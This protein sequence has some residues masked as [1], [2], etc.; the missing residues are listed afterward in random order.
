MAPARSRWPIAVLIPS[1]EICHN[2]PQLAPR[3]IISSLCRYSQHT[4]YQRKCDIGKWRRMH[5]PRKPT[6]SEIGT[7]WSA[8]RTQPMS[9]LTTKVNYHT[10]T[11]TNCGSQREL[12][13]YSFQPYL[14][15]P[16]RLSTS[17]RLM[18]PARSR[19][20]IALLVAPIEICNHRPQSVPL[21]NISSLCRYLQHAPDQRK[22]EIGK[23]P[24]MH[25]PRKP[26]KSE[27]GTNWCAKATCNRCQC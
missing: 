24:R 11:N 12:T 7:N 15:I 26:S 1:I 21:S 4:Q 20:Q 25:R 3:N 6:K 8:T 22:L 17:G 19:W 23:W 27:I 9:R 18:P 16:V 2:K 13:S 5:R 10:T 14:T